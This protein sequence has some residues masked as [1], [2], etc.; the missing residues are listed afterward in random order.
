M[1]K[2]VRQKERITDY[3]TKFSGIRPQ[4]V[5]EDNAES[6]EDVQKQA[7]EI[8]KDRIIVGHAIHNDLRVS[9]YVTL[10]SHFLQ[11]D[12]HVYTHIAQWALLWLYGL[13][14]V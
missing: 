9:Y 4:D 14:R 2:F 13:M 6:F 8:F 5:S 12:K 3:R 10:Q 11:F 1:D 7:A